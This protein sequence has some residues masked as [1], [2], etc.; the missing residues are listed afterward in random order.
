MEGNVANCVETEQIVRV[1][2]DAADWISFVQTRG[3]IPLIWS[4][5]GKSLNP[6]VR[7]EGTEDENVRIYS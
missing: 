5:S 3:S 7:I 2:G 6:N 1:G 4:Q